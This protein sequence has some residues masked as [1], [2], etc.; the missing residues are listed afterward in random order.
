MLRVH[1]TAQHAGQPARW[2]GGVGGVH[3]AARS[4]LPW[5]QQAYCTG[6]LLQLSLRSSRTC[7]PSMAVRLQPLLT[8][9]SRWCRQGSATKK[10]HMPLLQANCPPLLLSPSAA[11]LSVILCMSTL[12]V[13]TQGAVTQA[14]GREQCGAV[15][16]TS[17]LRLATLDIR[18]GLLVAT[19]H[20]V[21]PCNQA[22]VILDLLPCCLP[23]ILHNVRPLLT[24]LLPLLCPHAH[25]QPQQA[26]LH[27][28]PLSRVHA[29][30]AVLPQPPQPD[31]A[32][33]C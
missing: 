10:L 17:V 20:C 1:S 23:C 2:V 25:T 19:T 5:P 30:G 18:C 32:A 7:A 11:A 31:W 8:P 29:G 12:S 28:A 24:S 16:L 22:C 33:G 27:A 4:C 21:V 3:I 6:Q 9:R 14:F 13:G 15:L 26:L